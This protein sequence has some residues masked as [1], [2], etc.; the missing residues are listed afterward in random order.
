MRQALLPIVA[1][2]PISIIVAEGNAG[3]SFD[4]AA[5]DAA[6]SEVTIREHEVE[7]EAEDLITTGLPIDFG[8]HASDDNNQVLTYSMSATGGSSHRPRYR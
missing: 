5:L 7:D 8:S 4:D 3:P 1:T 2:M 6:V